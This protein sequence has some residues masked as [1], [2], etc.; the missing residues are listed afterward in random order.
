MS[1]NIVKIK[2]QYKDRA[3]SVELD[4]PRSIES[5]RTFLKVLWEAMEEPPI[6]LAQNIPQVNIDPDFLLRPE[7]LETNS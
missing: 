1:N 3:T 4:A 7:E 6:Q 5:M 2:L